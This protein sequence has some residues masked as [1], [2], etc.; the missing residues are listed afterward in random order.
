MFWVQYHDN[1]SGRAVAVVAGWFCCCG[2]STMLIIMVALW[3]LVQFGYDFLVQYLV[4]TSGG[5]VA[6]VAVWVCCC[7]CSTILILLVAL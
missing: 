3:L 2:C 1:T 5:A 4:N 7:G 6:V